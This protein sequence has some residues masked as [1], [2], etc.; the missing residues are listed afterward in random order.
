MDFTF[1]PEQ[2]ALRDAVRSFLAAEAPTEYVRRMAEHDETGI[3]PEL[4][5]RSN[6]SSQP[7][8]GPSVIPWDSTGGQP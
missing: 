3:T 1:S 5:R 7:A 2:G 4:W 8:R 6:Y